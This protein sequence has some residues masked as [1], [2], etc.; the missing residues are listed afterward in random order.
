MEHGDFNARTR[1][2]PRQE[3]LY[4]ETGWV[5]FVLALKEPQ[6]FFYI[7]YYAS[8]GRDVYGQLIWVNPQNRPCQVRKYLP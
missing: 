1:D 4:S 2:H 7:F 8:V 5:G 3:V 6:F